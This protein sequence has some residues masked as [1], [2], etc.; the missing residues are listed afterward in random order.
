MKGGLNPAGQPLD[1]VV[2]KVFKGYDRD[3]YYLWALTSPTNTATGAP[4][5][6]TEKKFMT[7]VVE[8]WERCWKNFVQRP[9]LCVATRQRTNWK[10]IR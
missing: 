2:N 9:V 4:H 7:W 6:H 1:K 8:Y 3:I 10:V 5:P